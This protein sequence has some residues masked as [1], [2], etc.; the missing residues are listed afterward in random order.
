MRKYLLV[1]FLLSPKLLFSLELKEQ[2]AISDIGLYSTASYGYVL[3]ANEGDFKGSIQLTTGLI[4]TTWFTEIIK[5]YVK[6][7]RPN[8]KGNRS[9]PSGH[10]SCSF[11]AAGYVSKRYGL[12]YGL[13]SLAVATLVGALRVA[14]NTHYTHD[15]VAGSILGLLTSYLFT[16]KANLTADP[17]AK[18]LSL[19]KAF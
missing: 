8:G 19:K 1:L 4:F 13:P 12:Q 6:E 15:V 16:S 7:E 10:T 2:K 17:T 14:T 3:S 9:F 11:Y 5:G 18:T